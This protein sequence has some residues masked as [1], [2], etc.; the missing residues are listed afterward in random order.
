[1][2]Y[3]FLKGSNYENGTKRDNTKCLDSN[4]TNTHAH[5]RQDEIHL[6]DIRHTDNQIKAFL[7]NELPLCAVVLNFQR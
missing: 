1:M 7:F 2:F 5:R 4:N 6:A 3:I